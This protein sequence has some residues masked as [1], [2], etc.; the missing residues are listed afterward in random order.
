MQLAQLVEVL[1]KFTLTYPAKIITLHQGQLIVAS[2]GEVSTTPCDDAL[3]IW[4]G[5]I[6]T[7]AAVYWLQQP[8]KAFQALTTAVKF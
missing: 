7:R 2:D 4:R 3:V 5:K 8:N 6:A 1:H